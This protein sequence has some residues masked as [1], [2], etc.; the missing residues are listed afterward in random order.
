[1]ANYTLKN[2]VSSRP[3]NANVG[4]G[5]SWL[6][7]ENNS[8][9]PLFANASYITN[10]SDL[11]ISLSASNVDI[12][13]VHIADHTTGLNADVVN[14][15]VGSGALRVISQD[16]ESAEDDV[17]IGDRLGNFAAVNKPLSAL[18]VYIT[19]PLLVYT[20]YSYVSCETRTSGNPSFTP[21][22]IL[23]HNQSNSDVDVNLT[24]SSGMSC[25]IPI[26]KNTSA[27]HI[28]SLNLSVS[29]VNNYNGCVI[30]FFA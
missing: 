16:L 15:G 28:I 3:T 1:M 22:Q 9:K 19:N 7:V 25:N 20:Q 2:N 6:E 30:N 8:G 12:G 17:T 10:F 5:N 14:V 21:K 11:S 27:N 18:N 24:L 29:S 26:G 4:Y 23:I 13:N